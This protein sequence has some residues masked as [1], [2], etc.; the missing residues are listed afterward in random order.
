MVTRIP[1]LNRNPEMG[2]VREG[3]LLRVLIILAEDLKLVPKTCIRQLAPAYNTS[4][5]Y[6]QS[7]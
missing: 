6:I 1:A 3:S 5:K 4:S 7:L 2:L